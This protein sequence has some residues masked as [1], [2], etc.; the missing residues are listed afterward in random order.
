MYEFCEP[1][2]RTNAEPYVQC[3]L[4]RGNVSQVAWIPVKFAVLN[5][6]IKLRYPHG[7]EDGWVVAA[8]YKQSLRVADIERARRAFDRVLN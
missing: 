4:R 5:S 2:T 7:W 3:W 1:P 8:C 6:T